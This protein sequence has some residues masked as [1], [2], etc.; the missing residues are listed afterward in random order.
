MT[1]LW[2]GIS[3]STIRLSSP[4]NP[5]SKISPCGLLCRPVLVC[6]ADCNFTAVPIKSL[7]NTGI[8]FNGICRLQ[9]QLHPFQPVYL[10]GVSCRSESSNLRLVKLQLQSQTL[11]SDIKLQSRTS[12]FD[13]LSLHNVWRSI[14]TSLRA[15]ST[16]LLNLKSKKGLGRTD[17]RTEKQT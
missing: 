17:G 13:K 2:S 7:V 9:K 8:Y 6:T 15:W 3:Y 16:R 10:T 1:T 12:N 5:K 14:K 11:I 4:Q